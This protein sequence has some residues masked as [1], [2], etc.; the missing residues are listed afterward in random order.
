MTLDN[1]Q[2]AALEALL[3][4]WEDLIAKAK[5]RDPDND[6]GTAAMVYELCRGDLEAA[7]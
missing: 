7:L 3:T 5:K 4:K 1:N 2:P 6:G